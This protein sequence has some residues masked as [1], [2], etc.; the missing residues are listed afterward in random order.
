MLNLWFYLALV[1]GFMWRVFDG[2]SISVAAGLAAG[3]ILSEVFKF[4]VY[5]GKDLWR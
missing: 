3:V 5:Y 1:V 4:A 2:R